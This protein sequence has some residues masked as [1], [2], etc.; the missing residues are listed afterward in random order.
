MVAPWQSGEVSVWGWTHAGNNS[1]MLCQ[2]FTIGANGK[3]A[4]QMGLFMR[5]DEEN[6]LLTNVYEKGL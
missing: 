3:V 2:G 6:D 5:S 1:A 4:I